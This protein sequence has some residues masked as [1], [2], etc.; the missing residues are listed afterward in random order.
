MNLRLGKKSLGIWWLCLA[1]IAVFAIKVF[2]VLP[3]ISQLLVEGDN[4]DLM[5]LVQI[6]DWLSGQSWFDTTQ[7]RILP[8]EGISMHWS[9]YVDLGI[10]AIL[11][12][13]S[14]IIGAAEAEL[15]AIALWPTLLGCL[16]ILLL[17]F[18]TYRLFGIAAAIGALAVFLSWG[19]LGGE[20]IPTRID[21]H[22]L[23]ML[24]GTAVFY[25]ALL[26]GRA[27]LLGALA[28]ACTAL[29][30]AIGLEMLP[31]LAAIW[32]IMAL[33]HVFM[34]AG[35]G[36]W[37]VGF[38]L[39]L[40]VMAP[41][42]MAGQTPVSS[43]AVNY[44]DVLA[45]PVLALAAV[46]IAATLVPV[47]AERFLT[48]WYAR[49]A[50][51]VVVLAI[52]LWIAAPVLLHCSSGP[53]SA[54]PP[55]VRAIIDGRITEAQPI[56]L[57]LQR[58][59]GL[60]LRVMLPPC[61]LG[62]L[63]MI[64]AWRMRHQLGAEQKTAL[65]C[66]FV[67][68]LVG[69]AFAWIQIRAVNVMSP[70]VPLLAGVLVHGFSFIPRTHPLRALA[71]IGL[72]LA[73]PATVQALSDRLTARP[74]MPAPGTTP[75][76][77]ANVGGKLVAFGI[78]RNQ[79]AMDEIASLP[80]SLIFTNMNLGPVIL[81]YTAHSATSAPYHRSA[82]AYWNGVEAFA[83]EDSLQKAMAKSGADYLVVCTGSFHDRVR[84][85]LQPDHLPDW[86][87]EVTGDRKQ[88]RVFQVDKDA[89]ERAAGSP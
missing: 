2:I 71:V 9:R 55:E 75:L 68:V 80:P 20:F 39:A 4:D 32:G 36:Q 10:A 8:P 72:L 67:L 77:I 46:G 22:N 58:D 11:V 64:V 82:D 73:M 26:P 30:L 81:A 42:L 35:A 54:V 21:H 59:I 78:C 57:V 83:T 52:G 33:R 43:W 53:Y 29:A 88:V 14:W 38:G 79:A 28:G 66:A 69:L 45:P 60:L 41:L 13:L 24:C 65:L 47:L 19:K 31:A 84:K 17:G 56:P 49:L 3:P 62:L 25:L 23:Q 76:E 27:W 74:G 34:V 86:L 6:R 12:P 5:R 15:V 63:A 48:R 37:L 1:A 16:M 87:V 44:C 70:A 18:G 51:M 61:V 50:V 7:Y 85:F 40:G 89:L